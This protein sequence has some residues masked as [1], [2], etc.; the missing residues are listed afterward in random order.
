MFNAQLD[1]YYKKFLY[2]FYSLSFPGKLQQKGTY[3]KQTPE[4][5]RFH[6]VVLK[7]NL[8]RKK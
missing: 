2:N 6:R 7:E 1:F 8:Y 4:E 3:D 5:N